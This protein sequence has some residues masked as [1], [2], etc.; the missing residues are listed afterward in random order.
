MRRNLRNLYNGFDAA[1][2]A[3]HADDSQLLEQGASLL[4]AAALHI[5]GNHA[6]VSGCLALGKIVLWVARK[7]R[8]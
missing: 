2:T 1:K 6:G 7:P 5:E 3:G 4:Q 8:T